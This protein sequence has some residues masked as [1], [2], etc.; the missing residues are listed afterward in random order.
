MKE[1]EAPDAKIV[2]LSTCDVISTSIGEDFGDN[3]GEWVAFIFNGSKNIGKW[4]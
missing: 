1:Y 4:E 2:T 3:D